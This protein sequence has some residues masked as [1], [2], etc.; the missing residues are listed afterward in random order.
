MKHPHNPLKTWLKV[1]TPAEREQ[2]AKRA[3]TTPAYLYQVAG[4]H[5]RCSAE[6][7]IALELSSRVQ[8]AKN[9]KLGTLRR[10]KIAPHV[11]WRKY[12]ER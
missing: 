2:M 7:A 12:K 11:Q 3:G 8:R 1:A 9:G 5:S 10:T 6:L 4:G